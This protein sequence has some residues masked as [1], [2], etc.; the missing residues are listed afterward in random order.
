MGMESRRSLGRRKAESSMGDQ[1][2]DLPRPLRVLV[3]GAR[4]KAALLRKANW[5]NVEARF[6]R[7]ERK[8]L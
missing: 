7:G 3:S 2:R 8:L 6:I 5:E 1:G 4:T